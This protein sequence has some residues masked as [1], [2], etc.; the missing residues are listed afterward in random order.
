MSNHH[1]RCYFWAIVVVA[2][3]L[4]ACRGG[5]PSAASSSPAV[6]S[7]GIEGQIFIGPVSPVTREGDPEVKPFRAALIV[8]SDNGKAVTRFQ[9]DEQGRFRVPLQPGTYLLVPVVP[10]Q[11]GPWAIPQAI[12]VDDGKFTHVEISY[13]SGIR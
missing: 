10:E 3:M 5:L 7:S 2:L 12:S 4:G 11:G 13:D 6:G 8:K 1:H 9:T